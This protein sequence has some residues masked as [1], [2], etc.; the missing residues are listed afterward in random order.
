MTFSLH[1]GSYDFEETLYLFIIRLMVSRLPVISASVTAVPISLTFRSTVC[2]SISNLKNW[3]FFKSACYRLIT[4]SKLLA[5]LW[6][7]SLQNSVL[8]PLSPFF[9]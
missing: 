3:Q 6:I 2:S 5:L 9:G 1:L 8:S 7:L 4:V